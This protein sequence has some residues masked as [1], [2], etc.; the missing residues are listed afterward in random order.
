MD[1]Q[2]SIER[3]VAAE[4]LVSLIYQDHVDLTVLPDRK[5]LTCFVNVSY[6]LLW[7]RRIELGIYNPTG[8]NP[9]SN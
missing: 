2:R 7:Y 6:I 8:Y 5:A 4:K 1:C 9:A 3:K